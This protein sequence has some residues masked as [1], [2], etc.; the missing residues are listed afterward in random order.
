MLKRAMELGN[1]VEFIDTQKII[2]G[3]VLDKKNLR[4][5]LLTEHNR[6]V[7]ISL[8]RLCLKTDQSLDINMGRD[9]LVTTLKKIAGHRR[10][11]SEQID[12]QSLW[13]VLNSEQ[14][15]I[16]LLTMTSFCFP[17]AT[18]DDHVSATLRAFFNN[19]LYFKFKPDG[20]F[21]HT[22]TQVEQITD[23]LGK[24]ARQERLIHDG[25]AWLQNATNG[26]QVSAPKDAEAIVEILSSYFLFEKESPRAVVAKAIYKKAGVDSPMAIFNFLVHIGIWK[27]DEN[28]DLRRYQIPI[29]FPEEVEIQA[30]NLYRSSATVTNGRQDLRDLA[31]MTIDGPSTQ[32]FDDALSITKEKDDLVLGIHIADVGYHISKADPIDQEAMA[33]ASS[34]YLP[35]QKIPMLPPQLSEDLCSLKAGQERPAISTLIRMTPNAKILDC[36]IVPS[37][38]SVKQQLTFQE[39]DAMAS[40]NETF[41]ML[42]ALAQQYR[43]QRMDNGA[44]SIDLPEVNVWLDGNGRPNLT[45]VDRVGA[46]RMMV[47]ELMIL[48]N[49]MA[50]RHLSQKKMPAIYRSQPE[51]RERL[52][53]RDKGT[54]F[55]NWMQRKHINRFKLG[56]I[57]EPHS[58]LG[59]PGYVTGTSPIRKYTD[60][61]TQR[62]LRA[63][64][65]IETP[66]TQEEIDTIIAALE[67]PMAKVGRT[68]YA[69]HRYW[70][71]K[72]LEG[73]IGQK[74]EALVLFKRRNSFIVLL[75]EYLL[76]C[77]LSGAQGISLKPEDL[78]HVTIQHVN[79]RNDTIDVYFG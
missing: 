54:L 47:A 11:L 45:T 7:M 53:S 77:T 63:A 56:S 35:D 74:K 61:V 40:E 3:V 75:Q 16:D 27:P 43:E 13:Q 67:A 55:K 10:T 59:L 17:D 60:L 65:G 1:V 44:L 26:G 78:V 73:C 57:P 76:E 19:R 21:P 25:A 2:C 28:L 41:K 30:S 37:I 8:T 18:N 36:R 70:L 33:R 24:A 62:Q 4:L 58:G 34:I 69:R 38:V 48:A 22:V 5:R 72:Y 46:G 9:K 42:N 49:D 12:I 50:S 68:Q 66:Y 15:W 64:A 51:P 39:V 14:E 52:F 6:E 71:L 23:Q 20:F 32:D 29:E 79:A 31:L